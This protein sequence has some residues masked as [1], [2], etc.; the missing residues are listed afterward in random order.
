MDVIESVGEKYA[1]HNMPVGWIL[2]NDGY[3]CGYS[4]LSLVS[5][6][7]GELGIRTGLWTQKGVDRIKQEVADGIRVMKLDVACMPPPPPIFHGPISHFF[8]FSFAGTGPGKLYSMVAQKQARLTT[9]TMI[10]TSPILI[11]PLT[12]TRRT[13]YKC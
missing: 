1:E 9:R 7:L 8:F 4:N 11:I 13:D 12:G 10:H 2:P 5:D 3:G 6:K